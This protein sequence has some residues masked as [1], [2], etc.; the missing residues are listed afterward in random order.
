MTN[1]PFEAHE[2]VSNNRSG[3]YAIVNLATN[4][5]YIGS[6][7]K[8]SARQSGHLSKLNSDKHPNRYLQRSFNKYGKDYFVFKVVEYCETKDLIEREQFWINQFDFDTQLYNLNPTAG[9]QLG[10]KRSEETK[11]RISEAQRG[12]VLSEEHRNKISEAKKGRGFSEE[13]RKKMSERC[14]GRV[15]SEETRKKLSEVNSKKVNQ[16]DKLTGEVLATF[17]SGREAAKNVNGSDG[18]ISKVCNGKL[19]TAYGY[20]WQ[21]VTNQN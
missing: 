3:I 2:N 17:N 12:R 6:A 19:K 11:K 7:V 14:K 18:H 5:L 10:T 15:Q 1:Y 16:I 8:L 13:I 21:Y 4:K 20:R 9:S